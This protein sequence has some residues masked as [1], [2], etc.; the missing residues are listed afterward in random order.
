MDVTGDELA[1]GAAE[2]V[3][4]GDNKAFLHRH[5]IG[6]VGVVLQRVHDRQFGGAGIAEQ[7]R[8]A[9]VF[10]QCKKCGAPGDFVLHLSSRP[11][12]SLTCGLQDHVR[13]LTIRAV[14]RGHGCPA[15][16]NAR[17][18]FFARSIPCPSAGLDHGS[19]LCNQL[20]TYLSPG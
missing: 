13:Y 16:A 10:Q 6:E 15:S 5:H 8:D 14:E 12:G 3:G 4:H 11:P 7:M 17:G 19:Q 20:V 2:A 18:P 9:L 1:R